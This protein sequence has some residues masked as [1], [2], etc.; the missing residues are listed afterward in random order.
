ML[1]YFATPYAKI[2]NCF[3]RAI[4]DLRFMI[5]AYIFLDFGG[6]II[7]NCSK[8]L[9]N[10]PDSTIAIETIVSSLGTVFPEM[11]FWM[12]VVESSLLRASSGIEIPCLMESSIICL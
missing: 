10:V 1:L 3:L 4:T 12:V 6:D 5:A 2:A 7:I 9:S 8:N 11:I